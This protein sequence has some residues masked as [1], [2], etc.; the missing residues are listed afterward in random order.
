[1]QNT[2]IGIQMIRERFALQTTRQVEKEEETSTTRQIDVVS[3]HE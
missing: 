1:M 2:A 3:F